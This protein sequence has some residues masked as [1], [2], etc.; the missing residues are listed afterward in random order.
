MSGIFMEIIVKNTVLQTRLKERT[1]DSWVKKSI[2]KTSFLADAY[3]MDRVVV[4]KHMEVQNRNKAARKKAT[5]VIQTFPN[6]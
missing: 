1:P 6:R 3:F 4:K 5:K 2:L